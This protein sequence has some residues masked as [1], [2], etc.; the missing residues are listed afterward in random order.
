MHVEAFLLM[1]YQVL[2]ISILDREKVPCTSCIWD[3]P[4]K[5]IFM[6]T[7]FVFDFIG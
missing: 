4:S 1:L 5:F 2:F 3:G 7:I 6:L